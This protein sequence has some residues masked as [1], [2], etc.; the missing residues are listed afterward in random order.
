VVSSVGNRVCMFWLFDLGVFV[1][2]D[3]FV[4]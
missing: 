4:C 1:E 2:F 3:L